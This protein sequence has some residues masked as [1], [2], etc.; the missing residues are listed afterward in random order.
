MAQGARYR[1]R[2]DVGIAVTGVA[3]P[4]GGSDEKPVGLVFIHVVTPD[5]SRGVE[6]RFGGPRET[7]RAY[8]V[9]AALH[10]ARLLCTSA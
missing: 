8:S 3:G 10:L 7:V 2:A 9:T 1:L 5:G 4:G 6:H